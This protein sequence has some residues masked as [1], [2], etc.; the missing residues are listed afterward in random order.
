MPSTDTNAPIY[1]NALYRHGVDE[2]RRV[3]IPAKW[4]P[5]DPD[6]QFTLILWPANSGKEPYLLVLPPEPMRELANKL[7]AMPYSDPKADSLR[8][9]LGRNSDQVTLDKGG[10]ICIP[11]QMA[12]GAGIDKEAVLIGSFDRFEIWSPERY[13]AASKLDDALAGDAFKL[14]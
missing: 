5:V 1:Y 10:R 6:F 9:L 3:Q 14:I 11:E 13:E 8:R 12:R 4:R 2:K 7:K